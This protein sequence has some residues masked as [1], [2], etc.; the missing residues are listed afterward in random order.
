MTELGEMTNRAGERS[1]AI[2][3]YEEAAALA[4]GNEL[5]RVVA[6]A[7]FGLAK[8]YRDT[9][10]LEKAEDRAAKGVEASQKVGE[11]YE[12]PGRLALLARLRSDRGKFDDADRLYEQAEDVIDGLL[13]SVASLSAR[14][15]LIGAMSQIYIDHFA[16]A[17]DRLQSPV[18]A[19]EVLERARGR[20]AADVLSSREPLQNHGSRI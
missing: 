16:L 13:V 4:A 15:S 10:D 11:T 14:T 6:M 3:F 17:I 1:R 12:L 5:H 9:G 2:E 20:T 8:L 19:L 7:M 18:R